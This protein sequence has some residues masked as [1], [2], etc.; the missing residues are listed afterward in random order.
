MTDETKHK[1]AKELYFFF[2]WFLIAGL[3]CLIIAIIVSPGCTEFTN[4]LR[5]HGF[6]YVVRVYRFNP[7]LLQ[8]YVDVKYTLLLILAVAYLYRLY[9]WVMKWK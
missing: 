2:K 6:R 5:Q 8:S 7:Q 1:V 3:L 4:D 9:K